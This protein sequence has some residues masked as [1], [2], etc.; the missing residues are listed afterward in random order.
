MWP[1]K[2]TFF[3]RHVYFLFINVYCIILHVNVV[4]KHTILY[5]VTVIN[6]FMR[7]LQVGQD[8][9]PH[10]PRHIPDAYYILYTSGIFQ[11]ICIMSGTSPN[12]VLTLSGMCPGHIPDISASNRTYSRFRNCVSIKSCSLFTLS[13]TCPR[14]VPDVSP[15]LP[16]HPNLHICRD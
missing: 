13:R 16:R 10:C 6:F 1:G 2:C 8:V 3:W 11:A 9:S 14:H 15:T 5:Y 4:N 7:Q 12:I